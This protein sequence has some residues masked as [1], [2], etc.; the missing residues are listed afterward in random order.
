VP[1]V[2]GRP[3]IEAARLR[4]RVGDDM[5]TDGRSML[6][7]HAEATRDQSASKEQIMALAKSASL[8]VTMPTDAE[9]EQIALRLDQGTEVFIG[10]VP[11]RSS[12]DVI[13]TCAR[14]SAGGLTPV[15]HFAVRRIDS[16]E[17]FERV[18]AGCVEI[19]GV[20]KALLV[21]GDQQ[22]STGPFA[23]VAAALRSEIP[24]RCGIDAV[25]IAGYP[26]GHPTI[27]AAKLD[28]ALTT[29]LSLLEG[30]GLGRQIVTQF[31][32]DWDAL[33]DWFF[34]WRRAG[35][36]D[37]VSIGLV[38]PATA[39]TLVKFAMRCG[40]R[41]T[42]RGLIRGGSQVLTRPDYKRLV[43]R[44]AALA[45]DGRS[46]P[47]RAHFFSFGGARR[48]AGWI[49]ALRDGRFDVRDGTVQV[50]MSEE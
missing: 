43:V 3:E 40:V 27:P 44:L 12:A 25:A 15:P 19:G 46:G 16:S 31:G 17:A 20:R 14:V 2:K 32:F 29:K 26:E 18:L 42:A 38:G 13:G 39:S 33:A 36:A 37:L 41:T 48:T 23:N 47:L 22:R 21:A 49:A 35:A 5:V 30:Q 50:D 10:D 24:R 11:R 1:P 9:I 28:E 4:T 6:G 7:L 34:H 45:G 8:E